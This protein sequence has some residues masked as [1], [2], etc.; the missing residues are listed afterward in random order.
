MALI[1]YSLGQLIERNKETNVDLVYGLNNVRG[2]LNTKSIS[3]TL[4][5][6]IQLIKDTIEKIDSYAFEN[7]LSLK[8]VLALL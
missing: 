3:N 6:K 8:T 4:K 5:D 1:K 7:S 2:V